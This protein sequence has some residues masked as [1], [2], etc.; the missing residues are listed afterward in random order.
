M[1][2]FTPFVTSLQGSMPALLSVNN[3]RTQCTDIYVQSKTHVGNSI[4]IFKK[5]Q[6]SFLCYCFLY[7]KLTTWGWYILPSHIHACWDIYFIDFTPKTITEASQRRG[8]VIKAI[9]KSPVHPPSKH[10]HPYLSR[11]NSR[12]Q[13]S[14]PW[15]TAWWTDARWNQ[16]TQV[17]KCTAYTILPNY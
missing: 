14:L 7:T 3:V 13:H 4:Q 1:R 16:L 6:G 11:L 5:I 12:A 9:L 8:Q 15:H 10:W 17:S 2:W